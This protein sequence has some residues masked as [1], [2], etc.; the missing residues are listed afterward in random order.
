MKTNPTDAAAA[1]RVVEILTT[2]PTGDT[3]PA[4]SNLNEARRLAAEIAGQDKQGSMT[5]AVAIGLHKA[6]QLDL[7]LP[8]GE[9][10]AKMLNTPA[11]HLNYG[12]ILLTL[13][14]SQSD[15][16]E[17]RSS[18]ERAVA[19]YDLVLK[20]QPDS[21]E[22]INNKAWILHSYMG[23][24]RQALELV[25]AL[26]KRVNA[27]ALPGE[28]YDTLGSIQESNGKVRDAP[29][30]AYT[31]GFKKAPEH[32]ML[33]FH[34][35]K[36]IAS[37]RSRAIKALPYLKKAIEGNLSPQMNQ[38]ATRVVQLIDRKGSV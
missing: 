3:A 26:Q 17:Q 34:F 5:L 4:A 11:A 9:T 2:R 8:Y 18:L 1:S 16:K 13:A 32:P 7:A 31:A 36:M 35:G 10:A 33:N 25:L 28:F 22:A 29:G 37:D 15:P 30:A 14:E 23:Q 6:R 20:S 12:D 24:S 38:E 19:E 27:A 21:V